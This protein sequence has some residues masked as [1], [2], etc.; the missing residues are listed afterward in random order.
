MRKQSL[1]LESWLGL[2]VRDA[3]WQTKEKRAVIH[4][5]STSNRQILRCGIRRPPKAFSFTGKKVS[6]LEQSP[7]KLVFSLGGSGILTVAF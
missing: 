1:W 2:C 7:E 5:A 4:I 6:S 3:V